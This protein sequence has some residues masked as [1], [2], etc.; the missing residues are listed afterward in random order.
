MAPYDVTEKLLSGTLTLNTDEQP[1]LMY[2]FGVDSMK[3]NKIENMPIVTDLKR[4]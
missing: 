1:N 3:T 2:R 4:K